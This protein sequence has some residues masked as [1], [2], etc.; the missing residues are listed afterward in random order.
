MSAKSLDFLDFSLDFC[1]FFLN[2]IDVD[3]TVHEQLSYNTLSIVSSL[4]GI[5]NILKLCLTH[6]DCDEIYCAMVLS[7]IKQMMSSPQIQT[8][9]TDYGDTQ[10]TTDNSIVIIDDLMLENHQTN[11]NVNETPFFANRN[12]FISV[13]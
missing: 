13:N 8:P 1:L 6:P 5:E 11:V 4:G 7:S 9:N 10:C 2:S 12:Y 3:L